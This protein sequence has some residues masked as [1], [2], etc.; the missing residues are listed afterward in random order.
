MDYDSLSLPE[1]SGPLPRTIVDPTN[2]S[3][4]LARRREDSKQ[5]PPAPVVVGKEGWPPDYVAVH[6]WREWTRRWV[7]ENPEERIPQLIK[8]YKGGP[9]IE[10]KVQGCIDFILCWVDTY[11]PRNLGQFD[12]DGNPKAVRF[13]F[14]MFPKQAELVA[15]VHACMEGRG[16]ALIEKSRDMGAS[17]VC[18][19]ISVWL[20]LFWDG[21][22]VGWGSNKQDK[23]DKLGDPSSLF[24]K[25]RMA[26]LSL[27]SFLLPKGF[28]EGKCL[29]YMRCLNPETGATIIGEIG[30]NIGRGGRTLVYF[31]DEAAHLEH[32]EMVEASLSETTN[33]RV[34]ISS[35]SGIGTVYYRKRQA[36][37]DWKPGGKIVRDR[38]NV[39]VMDWSDHPAKNQAWF[40][41]KQKYYENSG[42]SHVFAQEIR[43]DYAAAVE[44]VIIPAKWVDACIDAHLKLGLEPSGPRVGAL[45]PADE[46]LDRNAFAMRQS[47]LLQFLDHWTDRDP[48]LAARKALAVIAPFAPCSFQYDPVGVGTGVK[49]ELN[50]QGEDGHLPKGLEIVPWWASAAPLDPHAYTLTHANG[51]PDEKSPKNKDFYANLKAQGWWMLRRRCE[52]TFELVEGVYQ[53]PKVDPA[54]KRAQLAMYLH[55]KNVDPDDLIS[56]PSTL[57]LLSEL[58][59]ELSQPTYGRSTALKILVNKTPEGTRSPNLGDAVMMAYWP[60]HG[61]PAPTTSVMKPII[62][63]MR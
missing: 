57:P 23:V 19:G 43:R 60:W 8:H 30:N 1:E 56:F 59:K 49:V 27:P 6:Q 48:G 17:W 10:S 3:I 47:F 35:V 62:V 26:I 31:V 16:G 52:L 12:A 50:R 20:W 38:V 34:D 2:L 44:G 36:G 4:Q 51:R 54:L 33:T 14:I 25:I 53:L 9:S 22:A 32:P 55:E 21:S 11:D 37:L 58:R 42:L 41:E 63:R 18:I 15:F 39:F 45:D 40:D 13:P 46:G 24:E 29:F 28:E 7:A 5:M 61:P